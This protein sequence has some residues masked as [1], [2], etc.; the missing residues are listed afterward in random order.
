VKYFV[1]FLGALAFYSAWRSSPEDPI[2]HFAHLGGMVFG[3]LYLKG[4]LSVSAVRQNYQRWKLQRMR[5]KFKV[6]DSQRREQKEK[7]DDFWI[8]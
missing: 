8:N 7:K 3:F 6:Y 1:A 2:A 4:L 5:K